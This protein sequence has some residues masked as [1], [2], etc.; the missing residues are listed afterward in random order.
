[1]SRTPFFKVSTGILIKCWITLKADT[2][3]LKPQSKYRIQKRV[4]QRR[5]SRRQCTYITSMDGGIIQTESIRFQC[6]SI[7]KMDV[8]NPFM[9][10]PYDNLLIL[11]PDI[12]YRTNGR[13]AC[14][15]QKRMYQDRGRACCQEV[16]TKLHAEREFV[17]NH[18]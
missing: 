15:I 4:Y 12:R 8:D 16:R 11:F 3:Y 2:M 6:I 13:T 9:I 5:K 17:R 7:G 1:M 14:I 10:C 18:L